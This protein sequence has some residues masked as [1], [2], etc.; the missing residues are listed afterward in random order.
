MVDQGAKSYCVNAACE[1]VLKYYGSEVDQH[2]L[3]QLGKSSASGGTD[4]EQM[5]KSLQAAGAKLQFR[6]KELYIY[7][8][9]M[10]E[11]GINHLIASYNT[12][13]TKL[14]KKKL[15]T[16]PAFWQYNAMNIIRALDPEVFKVVRTKDHDFKEFQRHVHENINN[17]TPVLWGVLLG[18]V[19]EKDLPQVAGG[20]MRLIIGY[21]DKS[22]QV[23]YS[24]SWGKEHAF[25]K[26]SWE[27]A[28]TMTTMLVLCQPRSGGR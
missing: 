17:G 6:C 21:D 20:H 10:S 13:A 15:S 23:I 24:D 3:A 22:D 8:T 25:K 16:N 27:D 7:K 4:M 2:V 19:K 14:K 28:W 12:A 9:L 5:L 1:R 26:M 18:I 11:S